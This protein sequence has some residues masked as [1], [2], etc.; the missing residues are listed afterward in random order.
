MTLCDLFEL[1][2]N[3]LRQIGVDSNAAVPGLDAPDD[4]RIRDSA[5]AIPDVA[6][7]PEQHRGKCSSR[8]RSLG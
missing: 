1:R 3:R 8:F 5:Q 7:W 2:L 4:R 6:S